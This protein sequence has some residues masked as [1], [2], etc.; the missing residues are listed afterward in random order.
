M[1]RA[2]VNFLDNV[3]S[4]LHNLLILYSFLFSSHK[5][6]HVL[7]IVSTRTMGFIIHITHKDQKPIFQ[8][9]R[10]RWFLYVENETT[11]PNFCFSVN[12][13]TEENE[14]SL[15]MKLFH[16]QLIALMLIRPNFANINDPVCAWN[17]ITVVF[18]I[19]KF[20]MSLP[21]F[22]A[23]LISFAF[24]NFQFI[25][26]ELVGQLMSYRVLFVQFVFPFW[27]FSLFLYGMSYHF[28]EM[29]AHL[30]NINEEV[31]ISSSAKSR[32]L[33]TIGHEVRTPLN[34]IIG[35]AEL[36]LADKHLNTEQEDHVKTLL[37]CA[38]ILLD[39]MNSMLEFA[40]LEMKGENEPISSETFD[41]RELLRKLLQIF[42]F[43]TTRKQVELQQ[44]WEGFNGT[45]ERIVCEGDE[46]RLK[47][48]LMNLL[49]NACKFTHQ[50][51][52]QL[53]TSRIDSSQIQFE[54][55]D[56]GIGIE[57]SFSKAVFAPF[58][59]QEPI[60][61]RS[62]GGIG[63][64]LSICKK[65]IDQMKGTICFKSKPGQGTTFYVTLPLRVLPKFP[66]HA[67]MKEKDLSDIEVKRISSSSRVLVVDDNEL[68]RKVLK[69]MLDN[70]KIA[71]D[72]ASSGFEAIEL[73]EKRSYQL[74]LMDIEMP[75]M[76]G[77]E[78]VKVIRE[79]EQNKEIPPCCIVLLSGYDQSIVDSISMQLVNGF[80]QKPLHLERLKQ[81]LA[82][83]N[84]HN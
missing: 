16:I 32:F 23:T 42:A 64:G 73:Y 30:R 11:N 15:L 84:V 51:H 81:L 44:S 74:I 24:S 50:G 14:P 61:H 8:R 59:Q 35:H 19:L 58:T 82:Q 6:F 41:L 9:F 2:H 49:S 47:T 45:E 67:V 4:I 17:V 7:S 78:T 26:K 79:L 68:N 69:K 83:K 70:L 36:I 76:S 39:S 80:I 28:R 18:S 33:S 52:V 48:V 27:F 62:Y 20:K 55:E 43:Q 40:K 56:T 38:N 72:C 46:A 3:L 75:G 10:V 25:T 54:I 37:D 63:L 53:K 29:Y 12:S 5:L 1:P 65:L 22:T 71:H 34:S 57:E 60:S 13:L 31:S 77:L 21:W 66:T